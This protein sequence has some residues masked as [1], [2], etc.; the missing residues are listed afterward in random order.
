MLLEGKDREL[1][2]WESLVNK[3]CK[4]L[5]L[6][7]GFCGSWGTG[8]RDEALDLT[9]G[10]NIIRGTLIISWHCKGSLCKSKVEIT[11]IINYEKIT[12][13]KSWH[14]ME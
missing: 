3:A 14:S 8:S 10:T 9:N 12:C 5:N 13:L 7:C 6:K 1:T 11:S 4:G 2:Y